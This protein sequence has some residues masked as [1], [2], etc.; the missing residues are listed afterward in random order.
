MGEEELNALN[1]S[2]STE[3]GEYTA[4]LGPSGSG[5][6]TLMNI[7]LDVLQG[8]IRVRWARGNAV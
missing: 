3:K 6:S 5:K 7:C 8:D 1:V 4:T 2:L